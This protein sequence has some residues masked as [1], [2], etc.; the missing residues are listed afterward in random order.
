[1]QAGE[2]SGWLRAGLFV[3]FGGLWLLFHAAPNLPDQALAVQWG[4]G[5]HRKRRRRR[6]CPSL[7]RLPQ[8]WGLCQAW[9]LVE[10]RG[11]R[12]PPCLYLKG[13]HLGP[14]TPLLAKQP[15]QGA[16]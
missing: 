3:G 10:G 1:M 14:A 6:A 9:V 4:P 8:G 13:P 5:K 7:T 2:Q 11:V 16:W 12:D 15:W